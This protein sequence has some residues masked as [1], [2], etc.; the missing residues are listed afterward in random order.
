M[1]AMKRIT[2][3]SHIKKGLAGLLIF[4]VFFTVTGFFILPPVLKSVLIKRLSETF[5]RQ[6]TIREIKVNPFIL[7]LDLKGFVIK[8]AKSAGTFFSFDELY[9]NFQGI[10]ILKGGLILKEVR[11]AGP[12]I[13]IVR[14]E[15]GRYNFSDLILPPRPKPPK[16]TKPLK[17][18]LY[19]IQVTRGGLDFYDGP[20]HTK[21]TVRDAVLMIPFISDFPHL[22]DVFV[23][24]RFEAKIND[25]LVSFYGK[26]KPF[27]DSYETVLN[28]NIKDFDIPN[29]IAYIPFPVNFR[30]SSGYLNTQ[31]VVSYRQYKNRQPTLTLEGSV[32]LRK[33][34]INDLNDNRLISLP[35]VHFSIASAE[36]F[37]RKMHLSKVL[38]M[39]P[40]IDITRSDNGRINLESLIPD[41][42]GAAEKKKGEGN[43]GYFIQADEIALGEG[44]I[45][46]E[47]LAAGR[48]FKSTLKDISLRIDHFSNK[49]DAKSGVGLSFSTE[50]GEEMRLAGDFSVEPFTANG[51]VEVRKIQLRKYSPYY[52][53]ALYFDVGSG[54]IDLSTRYSFSKTGPEPSIRLTDMSATLGSLTLKRPDEKEEF[55][56]IPLAAMK[57]TAIDLAKREVVVG[58]VSSKDGMLEIRRY[59]DGRF[60]IERPSQN[61]G[62][63][64]ERAEE[65][66]EERPW[67]V[68]FQK[69]AA[70]GYAVDVEDMTTPEPV[71]LA[72]NRIQFTGEEISTAGNARGNASLSFRVNNKGTVSTSGAVG[73]EPLSA[74]LK[75]NLKG[76][77]AT[78][79]QEYFSDRIGLI[80]TGGDVSA[81]G[82]LY[83]GFSKKT[84]LKTNYRG[85]ASI[86]K[87]SSIDTVD[88]EE[89]MR[90]ESLFLDKI[91]FS[92]AP[93]SL[94]INEVS[95]TDFYSRIIMNPDGTSNI[96]EIFRP[97]QGTAQAASSGGRG[98]TG[99]SGKGDGRSKSIKIGKVTLQ[100][101]TIDFTDHYIKPNYSANLV[102]IGGR[103]SGL[104]SEEHSFADVDLRGKLGHYAPLQITGK[105]H[106]LG[107]D[108]YVDLKA[109]F[110]DIDLS[111][112]S[113]YSGKYVGY[114][115]QK[116]QLSVSLQYQI[117][118]NRLDAKNR[119]FLDQLT[120][121]ER[122]DSPDATKL[123]V[124]LAI[125]LLKD[126]K[127]E[128]HLNIPVSGNLD[129]PKFSLGNVI[130]KVLVNI[131]VKAATAPFALL[132]AI[133]GGG[134]EISYIEF[135]YGSASIDEQGDKKLETIVKALHDRPSLDLE[136]EGH[137]DLQKDKEGLHQYLFDRKIKAQKLKEMVKKGLPT[138][139]VDEV[140]VEKDEYPKYLKMAYKEEKFP[141][142]KNFIGMAKD[143][144]A[145]EMEKLMLAYIEVKE[146]DLRLLASERAMN[147]K[148]RLLGSGKVEQERIFLIEP[149]SL[150]P[151]KKDKVKDSRVDFILK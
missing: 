26:T 71:R 119:V 51:T 118:K 99:D 100:G 140:K 72:L 101:G 145:P 8:E 32:D 135:A 115:I 21:H 16:E 78:P 77:D 113:P 136:I 79:F 95:L 65:R 63:K 94:D 54:E 89:F 102:E 15:D 151:E 50:A 27:S 57:E 125:A 34:R 45:S 5:H 108:I 138:I 35:E 66:K 2:S 37:S 88:A 124:K 106:P 141:K 70:S 6:V 49:A 14:G 74:D 81:N 55:L 19:N 87:L 10:S 3:R 60:S 42:N 98:G 40:E 12:Y 123:P 4:L 83:V 150:Q 47:D 129:D 20:N 30:V 13:N 28:I 148:E 7:S 147:V 17:F 109:D 149:R 22:V 61:P 92:S 11:L 137:V 25:T 122:V 114:T 1:Q 9:L 52:H 82:R 134:E 75:L 24:P 68:R 76:I 67:L 73:L 117:V 130:L 142:P 132:G 59:K 46:L 58:E 85:E 144:P 39:S 36:M 62:L 80:L 33:I 18:S 44:T 128:I 96:Q 38:C 91:A 121:G 143:L 133:F 139:P 120:L 104:S 127:G 131:L 97:G 56:R 23:Q 31:T 41:K 107:K 84:G 86:T 146:D 110:R 43:T 126:R 48:A 29:Y 53:E 64:E 112:E 111:P 69:I 103:I 90:W 105:I 116:G 93:F